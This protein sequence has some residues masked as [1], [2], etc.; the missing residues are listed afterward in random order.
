MNSAP[1]F[2]IIDETNSL[3]RFDRLLEA[4]GRMRGYGVVFWLHLQALSQARLSYGDAWEL[5]PGLAGVVQYFGGTADK[6]TVDKMSE[7]SGKDTVIVEGTSTNIGEKPGGSNSSSLAGRLN[8]MPDQIMRLPLPR[9][10]VQFVGRGMTE[11]RLIDPSMRDF[12]VY[13][14][15]QQCVE[16]GFTGP[17][18]EAAARKYAS[19][20]RARTPAP[21]QA[22][23]QPRPK[24]KPIRFGNPSLSL[25]R[26]VA[27]IMGHETE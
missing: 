19:G 7:Y 3:K 12:P 14:V 17:Q 6:P 16:N 11:G 10:L 13:Q 26:F 5:V 23:P 25:D 22:P 1:T 15:F 4:I 27:K 24:R 21:T 8:Y 20:P 2:V 18:A 9:Q